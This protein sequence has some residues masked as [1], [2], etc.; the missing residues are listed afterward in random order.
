MEKHLNKEFIEKRDP[1]FT[2]KDC[3][4]G[5][6][7]CVLINP[8]SMATDWTDNNAR[9]RSAIVRKSDGKMVSLS[10]P[11]F[12]NWGEKPHFQPWNPDWPIKGSFKYDGSLIICS[13]HNGE[14]IVRTRGTTSALSLESGQEILD[15]VERYGVREEMERYGKDASFLFEYISPNHV[16]VL[17]EFQEPTL[18]FLGISYH[19]SCRYFS[20][21]MADYTNP[22]NW[23]TPR[24]YY[25]NTI[26]YCI[27]DVKSWEGKEGVVLES[28]N[29][30]T[31]KKIK[32]DHYL[33]MH[34]LMFGMKS[35]D[36]VLEVFMENPTPKYSEFYNYIGNTMDFEIAENCKDYIRTIAVAYTKVI[37]KVD[38]LKNFIST[39]L[40]TFTRKE[41]ALE[42]QMN[43]SGWEV[44]A[45]FA[46]LDKCEVPVKIIKKAIQYEINSSKQ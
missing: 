25:W 45:A 13:I 26:E 36:N 35:L 2:F 33:K 4:I 44:S 8:T 42:I 9:F 46:L 37:M 3:V 24:F 21:G 28:P 43:Y 17:R 41:Q 1:Q 31:L 30:Q 32:S 39:Q 34:S 29:G 38:R 16:V 19:D 7:E 20:Y 12:T 6:D 14:F 11:K 27:A 22:K 18:V 15:L 23:E 10:L 5:G 40:P